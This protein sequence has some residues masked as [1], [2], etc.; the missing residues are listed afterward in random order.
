MERAWHRCLREAYTHQQVGQ[1]RPG[2]SATPSTSARSRKNAYVA[3]SMAAQAAGRSAG[4]GSLPARAR[5]WAAS[6]VAYVLDPITDWI[7]SLKLRLPRAGEGGALHHVLWAAP[8]NRCR[9][10][11]VTRMEHV[12]WDFSAGSVRGKGPF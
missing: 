2:I 10:F 6:V 4:D 11:S 8:R 7:G 1:S 5:G 9:L 12:G 3:A